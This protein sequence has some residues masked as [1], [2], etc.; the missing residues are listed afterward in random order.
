MKFS[1]KR[2]LLSHSHVNN[3]FQLCQPQDL[4]F[5]AVDF[6]AYLPP[7]AEESEGKHLSHSHLHGRNFEK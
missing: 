4:T 1:N 7:L 3:C 6:T 2:N 5:L